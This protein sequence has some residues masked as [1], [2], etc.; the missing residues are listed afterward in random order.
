[1]LFSKL[2]SRVTAGGFMLGTEKNLRPL[3]AS[4]LNDL[5]SEGQQMKSF[6]P[7]N[8]AKAFFESIGFEFPRPAQVSAFMMCKGGV[9]KTSSAYL[10][11]TRLAQYG[12]RVLLIDADSQ[13]NLTSCF[14]LEK[15][16]C[17]IDEETPVLV[18]L[19]TEE[20]SLDEAIIAINPYIHLIPSTPMNALLDNHIRDRFRNPSIAFRRLLDPILPKYNYL[21]FDCAPALSLGNA[22]IACACQS[23][24]LPVSPDRF[25]AM[26]VRQTLSELAKIEE[27][28]GIRLD[29]KLLLTRFD[30][31][32]FAS[33]HFTEQ[34][35]SL[36]PEYLLKNIIRVSSEIKNAVAKDEDLYQRKSSA[37]TDYDSFVR[38]FI[39]LK[40]KESSSG[41]EKD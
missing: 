12:A 31:R 28:F 2:S 5:V 16:Q 10:L 22:A 21:I 33:K 34:I 20:C 40:R 35:Q 19:L 13:A 1:M 30:A 7:P 11:A 24:V 23:I 9:G 8:K 41:T 26:G 32:E 14:H 15:Y 18:D 4:D 3:K 25:A 27:D 17:E 36:Y 39:N 38:E 37:K 29:K 6:L